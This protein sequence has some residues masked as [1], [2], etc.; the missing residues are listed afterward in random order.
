MCAKWSSQP[1]S[2]SAPGT[3]HNLCVCIRKSASRVSFTRVLVLNQ[4][5]RYLVR[6][7]GASCHDCAKSAQHTY[8]HTQ[9]DILSPVL[10][11]PTYTNN[12]MG[13]QSAYL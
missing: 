9:A 8:I 12:H 11:E 10:S 4:E 2:Q 1:V 13:S 6:F 7:T 3:A 5:N